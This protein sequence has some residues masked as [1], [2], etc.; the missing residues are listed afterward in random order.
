M[1]LVAAP[2][3]ALSLVTAPPTPGPPLVGFMN[4]QRLI[5]HCMPT[6]DAE[7][8][9]EDVCLG[10]IAGSVDQVLSHQSELP[11]NRRT[12]CLPAG[13]T[14][15]QIQHAVLTRLEGYVDQPNLAGATIVE[16]TMSSAYPC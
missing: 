15:G 13:T 8:G 7:V 11:I 4:A 1:V 3:I 5:D 2:L 14:I 16:R 6:A 9:M 12:V 10:Y